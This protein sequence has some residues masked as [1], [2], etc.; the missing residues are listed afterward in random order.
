VQ[1]GQAIHDLRYDPQTAS[2]T[3]VRTAGDSLVRKVDLSVSH[4]F[5]SPQ[6]VLV[7]EA[8]CDDSV[9]DIIRAADVDRLQMDQWA[10]TRG[11]V[12]SI[13]GWRNWAE[14]AVIGTSIAAVV[15][16]FFSVRS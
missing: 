15:Y 2:V 8:R 7:D 4:S 14:P 12:P 5:I 16:L 1:L 11:Q 13:G 9:S 6:G 3:Y 10:E